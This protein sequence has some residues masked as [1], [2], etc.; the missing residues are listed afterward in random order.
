MLSLTDLRPGT[1]FIYNNEP[2]LVVSSEHSKQGR[3]GAIMR[4]RIQNLFTGALFDRTFKGNEDFDE[5][6]IERKKAQ[7]LYKEGSIFNFMDNATY[8]QFTLTETQ[9]G[10]KKNYLKDGTAI[11]ILYF[12]NKPINVNLPIKI[13]LKVTYTEPGFK[14]N[15]Q[16]DTTK[17][18]T[19]E[20]G[21][22]VQVPLFVKIGDIIT[23]DTRYGTYIGRA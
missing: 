8:E 2:H 7:Y 17:P 19:L 20:S 9:I 10:E 1:T 22:E 18:A 23:V 12:D 16:S 3:G 5:A 11:E 4:T 14:G 6:E 21:A 15:T 13:D